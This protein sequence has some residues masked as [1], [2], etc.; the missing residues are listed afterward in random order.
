MDSGCR[1]GNDRIPLAIFISY[2]R[3]RAVLVNDRSNSDAHSISRNSRSW[4]RWSFSSFCRT[5]ETNDL[6]CLRNCRFFTNLGRGRCRLCAGGGALVLTSRIERFVVT[7]LLYQSLSASAIFLRICLSPSRYSMARPPSG[8][9]VNATGL[10]GVVL[11]QGIST[12]RA[13]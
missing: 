9:E 12:C 5:C 3:R 8:V 2:G 6:S 13:D 4:K 11:A 10:H 7:S 1:Q